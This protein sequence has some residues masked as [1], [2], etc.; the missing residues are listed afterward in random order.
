LK[1][2]PAWLAKKSEALSVIGKDRALLSLARLAKIVGCVGER[3]AEINKL[4]QSV[5]GKK[6][7]WNLS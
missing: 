6:R 4:E 3:R 5:L 2:L 1:S 7:G